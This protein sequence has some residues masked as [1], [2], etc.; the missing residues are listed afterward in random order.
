[1]F[2]RWSQKG[3][4]LTLLPMSP[5]SDP[6]ARWAHKEC[7][8]QKLFRSKVIILPFLEK[9][10]LNMYLVS[11][12]AH[13][14]TIQGTHLQLIWSTGTSLQCLGAVVPGTMEQNYMGRAS[15]CQH[16][17]V[18]LRYSMLLTAKFICFLQLHPH[19][20]LYYR[21]LRLVVLTLAQQEM[22]IEV[23]CAIV[24]C[25]F[26]YLLHC[27]DELSQHGLFFSLYLAQRAVNAHGVHV[28][29]VFSPNFSISKVFSVLIYH[30]LYSSIVLDQVCSY[31]LWVSYYIAM[32]A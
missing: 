1:M 9:S 8:P 22:P 6:S 29:F 11:I 13:K 10:F 30:S 7:L 28:W 15:E 26:A 18:M 23:A 32:I 17:Q 4:S 20:V 12:M 16:I 24:T 5:P 27:F 2:L 14:A 3:S 25:P 21:K 19:A 31:I